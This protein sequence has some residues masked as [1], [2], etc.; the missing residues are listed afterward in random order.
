M[1]REIR[2]NL[3]GTLF[4]LFFAINAAVTNKSIDFLRAL[5]T[6]TNAPNIYQV[7][8]A[9]FGLVAIL[10]T[11]HAVGYIFNSAYL[12][13]YAKI[14]SRKKQ[15][16][17]FYSV[18]WGF[19][20]YDIK[21]LLSQKYNKTLSENEGD[22]HAKFDK[23]WLDYEP[24]VFLSFFWQQAPEPLVSWVS[25]RHTAFFAGMTNYLSIICGILLSYGIIF[26]FDLGWSYIHIGVGLCS[27]YALFAMYSNAQH[28]RKEARQLIDLWLAAKQNRKFGMLCNELLNN[29]G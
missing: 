26:Y 25:R 2:Q 16:G 28:A 12:F 1:S 27:L 13:W 8:V 6:Q 15:G 20:S 17:S 21:N 11:S 29:S 9:I 23:Q 19:L 14:K 24:D 7:I 5:S 3:S 22:Q 18:E 10:L 4:L